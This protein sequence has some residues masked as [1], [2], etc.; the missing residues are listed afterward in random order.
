MRPSVEIKLT[1][2]ERSELE[3]LARGRK[4][5]RALSERAHIV[6]LAAEG[7]TDTAPPDV[8]G[9]WNRPRSRRLA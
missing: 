2:D 8:T 6:L 5:W 1:E 4:V 7:L 9:H 3:R